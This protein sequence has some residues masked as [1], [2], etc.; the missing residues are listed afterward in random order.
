MSANFQEC[1]K[2]L[3]ANEGGFTVD[4]GG[5]TNW[6]V[7]E[8]VARANGYTGDMTALPESTAQSITQS[9]YW[10]PWQLGSLPSWAAFQ[11]LDYVYNGGPAYKDAQRVCGVMVDG[12]PGPQTVAAISA[13]S[14]WEFLAKYNSRRLQYLAS[15]QQPQYADGRM[16]RISNNLLQATFL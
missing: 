11:I 2:L 16:N 15:L 7:T 6:G 3:A 5:Q 9:A 1:W 12:V 4:D 8:T 14:P 10:D 13:M